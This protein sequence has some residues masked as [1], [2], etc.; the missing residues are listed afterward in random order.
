MDY[1]S[2]CETR[3]I[4]APADRIFGILANP[5]RH[6]DIDGSGMLRG[7]GPFA[8]VRGVG[9]VFTM[10]MH[11]A[12]WGDYLMDNHVVEFEPNRRIAWEP[13]PGHEHPEGGGPPDHYRWIF[14]LDPDSPDTAVVTETYDCSRAS[15]EL[16]AAIK[17]GQ[18]RAASMRI[19]LERLDALATAE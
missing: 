16:R 7:G 6:I 14:D 18:R 5:A 2:V 11:N 8:V 1:V 19:T 9:D 13:T 10:K 15:L 12:E 3:R 17:D 4:A